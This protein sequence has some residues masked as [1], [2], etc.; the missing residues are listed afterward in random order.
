MSH[1]R[2]EDSR[3]AVSGAC[4]GPCAITPGATV[5]KPKYM[6][7]TLVSELWPLD[8]SKSRRVVSYVRC[9]ADE[10]PPSQ[11]SIF[12]WSL[13]LALRLLEHFMSTS[14]VTLPRA[15][16]TTRP[17]AVYTMSASRGNGILQF[18]DHWTG[19]CSYQYQNILDRFKTKTLVA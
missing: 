8:L 14:V 12:P 4:A 15:C 13:P 19:I 18:R 7:R 17:A 9:L 11:P 3:S 6:M 2:H 1:S 10:A 16:S 5:R